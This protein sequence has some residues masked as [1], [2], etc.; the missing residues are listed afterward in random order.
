MV[1]ID[2]SDYEEQV[3]ELERAWFEYNSHKDIIDYL[4]DNGFIVESNQWFDYVEKLQNYEKVKKSFYN[5]VM[6]NFIKEDSE[7]WEVVFRQRVAHVE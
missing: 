5:K 3:T 1:T 4:L 6:K 2:L 7:K